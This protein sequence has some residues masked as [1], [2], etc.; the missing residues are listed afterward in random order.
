MIDLLAGGMPHLQSPLELLEMVPKVIS[1]MISE[2]A[3]KV[4]LRNISY[5]ESAKRRQLV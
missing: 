4:D 2:M 3:T 1:D 5:T